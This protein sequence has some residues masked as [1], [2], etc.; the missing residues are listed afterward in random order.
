MEQR[1]PVGR[2]S[3]IRGRD[4]FA[5]LAAARGLSVRAFLAELAVEEEMVCARG[6]RNS[7][8]ADRT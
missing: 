5:A 2:R 1:D 4:R 6:T 3:G 8:A 7:M